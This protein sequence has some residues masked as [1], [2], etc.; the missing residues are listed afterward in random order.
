MSRASSARWTIARR[1]A[2]GR[3]GDLERGRELRAGQTADPGGVAV[4]GQ[5]VRVVAG[6]HE[7]Q[8][9]GEQPVRLEPTDGCARDVVVALG[10]QQ[11]ERARAQQR[12]AV[13]G[14]VLADGAGQLGMPLV[15][16]ATRRHDEAR[17]GARERADHDLAAHRL[18]LGGELG[19]GGVELG[20]HAV[21]GGHEAVRGRGEAHAAAVAL[22][23][24]DAGLALELGERLR[25]RRRRVADHARD[26]GDRAAPRQ[27][28]QEP[29]SL[30]V[31]HRSA[32]LTLRCRYRCLCLCRGRRA[33][34][35]HRPSPL[36]A[37][38]GPRRAARVGLATGR[39]RRPH[40]RRR[41]RSWPRSPSRSRWRPPCATSAREQGDERAAR[42]GR[43]ARRARPPARGRAAARPRPLPLRRARRDSPRA[44][45]ACM[46][47]AGRRDRRRRPRARAPRRA[48]R[49][50][51]PRRLRAVPA[52]RRRQPAPT[53]DLTRRRGRY[54][55]L[56]I[57]SE[58]TGGVIGHQY[59]ALVDFET[60]R[61]ALLQDHR[62]VG[63]LARPARHHAAGLR[64]VIRP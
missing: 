3:A 41:R 31:E 10:D 25:D 28:A 1:E 42:A 36:R 61:Y 47:D 22:E 13:L 27:L 34:W 35:V 48:R 63:P 39:P 64:R 12:D 26:L 53:R 20:Q 18:V 7:Q 8:R 51:P 55:C 60:G 6:G 9:L 59:R 45:P 5:L 16:P 52:H 21:G 24:R 37:S 32:Q 50:D 43:A 14:L 30:E 15:E 23:Q 19:L 11:V 4:G 49:P 57:T 62:P 54:S 33:H 46:D 38:P 40:R 17:G 44:R 56:A 2:G 58:F 29:E